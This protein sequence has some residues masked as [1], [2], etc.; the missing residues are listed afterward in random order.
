MNETGRIVTNCLPAHK[1]RMSQNIPFQRN[2]PKANKVLAGET[3]GVFTFKE[4]LIQVD[5]VLSRTC[6]FE[7]KG[8]K[9]LLFP[10]TAAE[11]HREKAIKATDNVNTSLDDNG[12]AN[13]NTTA[14]IDLESRNF[15]HQSPR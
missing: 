10:R 7:Q 2:K 1:L 14:P 3:R 13:I 4:E 5:G 6:Q 9:K 8:E 11:F 12:K 15:T